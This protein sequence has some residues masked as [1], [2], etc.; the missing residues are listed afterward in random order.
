VQS[1]DGEWFLVKIQPYESEHEKTSGIVLSL[2]DI[3]ERKIAEQALLRQHELMMRVLDSNPSAILMLDHRG[4]IIY[5]NRPGQEL[6][7]YDAD[8]L[9]TMRHNDPAFALQAPDG[10]SIPDGELPYARILRDRQATEEYELMMITGPGSPTPG[11]RPPY[12]NQRE[13]DIR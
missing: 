12:Q 6:L 13:S 8:K 2:I 3:T 5:A 9:T 4:L 1:R 7:G 10:A 11:E